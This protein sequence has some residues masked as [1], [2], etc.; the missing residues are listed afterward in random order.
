VRQRHHAQDEG[1]CEQ[2]VERRVEE[3]P[4]PEVVPPDLAEL[5][6]L[7]AHEPQRHGVEDALGDVQ[8]AGRVD[9][10]HGYRV[11]GQVQHGEEQLAYVLV[12]R[13]PHPVR[14]EVSPV[15]R[16]GPVLVLDKP[17][18]VLVVLAEP[19]VP[20]VLDAFLI[21]RG[22]DDPQRMQVHCAFDDVGGLRLLPVVEDGVALEQ[23][24]LQQEVLVL[25]CLDSVLHVS[26][27]LAVPHRTRGRNVV[28]ALR[29]SLA[30][31]GSTVVEI[32]VPELHERQPLEPSQTDQKAEHNA[33]AILIL[34]SLPG[35]LEHLF[36]DDRAVRAGD[37]LGLELAGNDLL[38]L[39]L[40]PEGHLGDLLG[41]QRRGDLVVYIGRKHCLFGSAIGSVVLLVYSH[42]TRGA[43]FDMM[44]VHRLRSSWKRPSYL[45]PSP[46]KRS[47]QCT[48]VTL[49]DLSN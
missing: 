42:G 7:V 5:V 10:V 38:D 45:L 39:I 17:G 2:R 27:I 33:C 26:T 47:C 13:D 29:D 32:G 18:R 24:L 48:I 41:R 21:P 36:R 28:H 30:R 20:E 3:V 40:Q 31:D 14:V 34:A 19:A 22:P 15:A 16:I 49:R 35:S 37:N 23:N 8:V 25:L 1:G 43:R 12:E 46:S 6:E 4:E 9:R 11:E 44:D